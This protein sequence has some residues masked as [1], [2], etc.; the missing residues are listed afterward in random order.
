M[1]SYESCIDVVLVQPP[2]EDFYLTAKRTIPYG[3][4][5]L[6]TALEEAGFRVIILD[7]LAVSKSRLLSRPENMAHLDD[8]YG[9][10]DLSP[11]S[12]FHEYRHFGSSFNHLAGQIQK[13]NPRLVGISTLFTPYYQAAEMIALATRQRLPQCPIVVGGHHASALPAQVL[14][15][16]AVDFVL[17]GEAEESL[18]ALTS[19]L[20]RNDGA[21]GMSPPAIP[22]LVYRGADG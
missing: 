16:S 21:P 5:L 2:I 9:R 10:K 14:S 3:L 6:A 15:C 17:R 8:H 11:F 4:M 18:P 7:G 12:L 19:W 22:G 20:L 13:I 1:K